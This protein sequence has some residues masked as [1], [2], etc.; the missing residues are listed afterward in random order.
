MA[1]GNLTP[2]M[3]AW[4]RWV[5]DIESLVWRFVPSQLWLGIRPFDLWD[6]LARIGFSEYRGD[7][8]LDSPWAVFLSGCVVVDPPPCDLLLYADSFCPPERGVPAGARDTAIMRA[9]PAVAYLQDA[10]KAAATERWLCSAVLGGL[11]V[12]L[13][14]LGIDVVAMFGEIF[15]E[16]RDE[17]GDRLKQNPP[18]PYVDPS[19]DATIDEMV[20]AVRELGGKRGQDRLEEAATIHPLVDLQCANWYDDCGWDHPRIARRFGWKVG[21]RPDGQPWS[22]S[23]RAHVAAGRKLKVQKRSA[24]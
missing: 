20:Q 9:K 24:G 16:L 17:Y 19:S 14:P 2:E 3:E 22:E 13:R 7:R 8:F 15:A 10:G 23:V 21:Q 12:R 11:E 18:Q 1:D 5:E 6:A 4:S